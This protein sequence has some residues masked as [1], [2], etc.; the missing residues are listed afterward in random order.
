MQKFGKP[1]SYPNMKIPGIS[2]EPIETKERTQL[3][4]QEENIID[5]NFFWGKIK[6]SLVEDEN[7][8]DQKGFREIQESEY[9]KLKTFEPQQN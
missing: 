7:E 2:L 9:L 5:P 4:Y 8:E 6:P 1:P 3:D